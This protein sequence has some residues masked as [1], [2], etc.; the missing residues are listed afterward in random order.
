[1]SP[2]SVT[3]VLWWR[4][5]THTLTRTLTLCCSHGASAASVLDVHH[6]AG[7]K[8]TSLQP[9]Q[10]TKALWMSPWSGRDLAA[11]AGDAPHGYGIYEVG[12]GGGI[13][14]VDIPQ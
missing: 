8:A 2:V 5:H 7:N 1:M 6:S 14:Q 9:V 3:W 12:G 13:T 10:L 11:Q 4:G